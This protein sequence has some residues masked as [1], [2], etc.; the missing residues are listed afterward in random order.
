MW[1]VRLAFIAGGS[2][3]LLLAL[4]GVTVGTG[5]LSAEEQLGRAIFNDTQ[6][7]A[8]ANESCATCHG[9][10]YGFT[11]PLDTINAHGAVYEGSIPGAFGNRKPPSA[12]YI[13]QSPVLYQDKKGTWIGGAFWDGRATGWRLGSP[14]AEQA[15][16]PFLNP[17]EQALSS[18][19]QV[20]ARVCDPGNGYPVSFVQVWGPGACTSPD[21]Y[22]LVGRSVAAYEASSEVDQF[23]SKF[24]L[25]FGGGAKLTQQERRGM[26]L[27]NGQGGCKACHPGGKGGLFTDY[28]YDNLG[29]PKNPEN[30]V[31]D[32]D[33]G[34]VDL[35]LGGFL[36]TVTDEDGEPLYD[37]TA[38][39]GKQKVP[40]LRNVAKAPDG[41]TKAFMHN[42]YFKTLEQVVHFYNTR[43]VLPT[44]SGD[45]TV[46]EAMANGCWPAPEYAA[47]VNHDELG[48]LGLSPADEAAIVAYLET[49]S[50]G[51]TP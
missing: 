14:T 3:A 25:S 41:A 18:P 16:G 40:T 13:S 24:D 15:E 36:Q 17:K 45:F 10:A 5:A 27:F 9:A 35:G 4:Y 30:P 28:S 47:T 32:Y 38:E 29:V 21:A 2:V 51:Y 34:F 20:I 46:D 11:G 42:G 39:L 23:S 43:D 44:C 49:L 22:D 33:P 8:N 48:D 12:A 26:A 50:D 7:S 37:Y 19:D 1:R 6:L 31:Y